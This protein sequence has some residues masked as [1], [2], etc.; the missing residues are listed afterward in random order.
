MRRAITQEHVLRQATRL[1]AK[2][3]GRDK[4]LTMLPT[5]H[6]DNKMMRDIELQ[7]IQRPMCVQ[8]KS[9]SNPYIHAPTFDVV[10]RVHLF[11]QH[12]PCSRMVNASHM[13]TLLLRENIRLHGLPTTIATDQD[14]CFMNFNGTT[15]KTKYVINIKDRMQRQGDD[16]NLESR[17]TLFQGGEMM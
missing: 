7:C 5:H 9:I 6:H 15:L 12:K 11:A 13:L 10:A 4:T 17:T 2:K 1:N 3:K 16:D 8:A 14:M